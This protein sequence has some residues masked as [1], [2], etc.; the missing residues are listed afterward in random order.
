MDVSLRVNLV[1]ADP[2]IAANVTQVSF[3]GISIDLLLPF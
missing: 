3:D 1:N 2:L